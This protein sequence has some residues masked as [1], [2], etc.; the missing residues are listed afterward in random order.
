MKIPLHYVIMT[1]PIH[2]SITW[3]VTHTGSQTNTGLG[4]KVIHLLEDFK[5]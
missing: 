4:N 5:T 3:K 2:R 1:W